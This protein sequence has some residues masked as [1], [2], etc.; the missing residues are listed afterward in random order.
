MKRER[1]KRKEG[2]KEGREIR[3]KEMMEKSRGASEQA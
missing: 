1:K 2:R 3:N